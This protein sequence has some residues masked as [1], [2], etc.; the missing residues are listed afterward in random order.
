MK[1]RYP[2]RKDE[3]DAASWL[4]LYHL[5]MQMAPLSEYP[6]RKLYRVTEKGHGVRL[7]QHSRGDDV[8]ELAPDVIKNKHGLS[9]TLSRGDVVAMLRESSFTLKGNPEPFGLMQLPMVFRQDRCS[10]YQC[11]QSLWSR[12]GNVMFVCR[13]GCTM[14]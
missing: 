7:R 12:T 2:I 4:A 10:G 9:Q 8:R 5:Y 13:C 3:E 1:I 6:K 14:L 11:G